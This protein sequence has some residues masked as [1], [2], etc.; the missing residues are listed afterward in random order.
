MIDKMYNSGKR[1]IRYSAEELEN[2]RKVDMVDFLERH[3]GFNFKRAGN[4]SIGREH[5]SIVIDPDRYTWHWYSQ[6]L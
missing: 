4:Y 6:G 5:D 3:A 2:A 1:F